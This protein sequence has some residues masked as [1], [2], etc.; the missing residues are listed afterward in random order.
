MTTDQRVKLGEWVTWY[1]ANR[2]RHEGAADVQRTLAF[3]AKAIEGLFSML[4]IVA[5]AER[6]GANGYI[7]LPSL[8]RR[9]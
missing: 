3:Q 4:L 9:G 8:E 1:R 7:V 5:D 6:G 2:P